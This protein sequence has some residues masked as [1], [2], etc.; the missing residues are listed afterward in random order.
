MGRDA[1]GARAG[2]TGAGGR[3]TGAG[4]GLTGAGIGAGGRPGR[5]AA[6]A[7]P[8][9]LAGSG[10]VPESPPEGLVNGGRNDT[11]GAAARP[12]STPD[13]APRPLVRPV[14]TP[15]CPGALSSWPRS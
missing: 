3:L 13:R 9:A 1:D 15:P 2:L 6:R 7:A 4:A 14:P 5:L 8:A 11:I 12:G 10:R